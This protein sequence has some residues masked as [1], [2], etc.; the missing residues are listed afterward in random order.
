[1]GCTPPDTPSGHR[2]LRLMQPS[3]RAAV[4]WPTTLVSA[5]WTNAK[6]R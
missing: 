6:T 3:L 5:S 2:S 4:S 1:M